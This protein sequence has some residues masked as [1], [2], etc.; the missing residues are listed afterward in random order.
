MNFLVDTNV[1]LRL[2]DQ[3]SPH[4]DGCVSALETLRNRADVMYICAQIIG[5]QL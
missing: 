4:H 5:R 1:L 3:D 2:R